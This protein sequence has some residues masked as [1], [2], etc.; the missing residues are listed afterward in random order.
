MGFQF[1]YL[2]LTLANTKGHYQNV[3]HIL[4]VNILEMV[5]DRANDSSHEIGSHA[6][7][8]DWHFYICRW[9]ILKVKVKVM[10]ISI[11]NILEMV[12]DVA[13]ITIAVKYEVMYRLSNYIFKFELFLF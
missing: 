3:R 2:H 12:T 7:A 11:A 6:Q 13:N 5:K 10:H 9:T 1:A 8:F 4:T